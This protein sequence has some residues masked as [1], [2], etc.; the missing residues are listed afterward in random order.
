MHEV[1]HGCWSSPR[2]CQQSVLCVTN[3]TDRHV[4]GFNPSK[5]KRRRDGKKKKPMFEMH[6]CICKLMKKRRNRTHENLLVCMQQIQTTVKLWEEIE[7]SQHKCLSITSKAREK[8]MEGK[9]HAY[10]QS[11]E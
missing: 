3:A 5:I 7:I 8:R 10:P 6:V 11:N 9:A 1:P 4:R 2:V